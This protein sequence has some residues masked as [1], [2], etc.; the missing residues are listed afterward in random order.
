M[1]NASQEVVKGGYVRFGGWTR[2]QQPVIIYFRL[3]GAYKK[4]LGT[5]E[6]FL[7]QDVLLWWVFVATV[8]GSQFLYNSDF[9][10]S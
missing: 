3:L 6:I 4:N 9:F 5:L 10:Y 1:S 8:M 2:D 7:I